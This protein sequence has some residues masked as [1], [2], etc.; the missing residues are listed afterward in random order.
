MPLTSDGRQR[1]LQLP[2]H[3]LDAF[4]GLSSSLPGGAASAELPRAAR[5]GERCEFNFGARPLAFP[6]D[7]YRPLVDPPPGLQAAQALLGRLWA[8]MTDSLGCSASVGR[9]GSWVRA[10]CNP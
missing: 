6:L 4:V 3:Q 8:L 10:L 7:G 1:K 2:A 5:A 9:Q